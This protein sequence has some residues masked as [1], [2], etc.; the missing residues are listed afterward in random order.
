[1]AHC[2]VSA[3]L[4]LC[5]ILQFLALHTLPPS[6][7]FPFFLYL[8]FTP[9]FSLCSLSLIKSHCFTHSLSSS[10]QCE[11]DCAFSFHRFSQTLLDIGLHCSAVFRIVVLIVFQILSL[12]ELLIVVEACMA[13]RPYELC[14]RIGYYTSSSSSLC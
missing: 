4:E 13:Q 5:S 7:L 1:M 3:V 10:V 14:Q 12:C 8:Y 2:I 9:L 6:L 11:C